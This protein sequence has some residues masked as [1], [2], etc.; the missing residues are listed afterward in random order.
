MILSSQQD[1]AT[2][3]NIDSLIDSLEHL[4]PEDATISEKDLPKYYR[5]G[6]YYDT[7]GVFREET[8]KDRR[9]K[10]LLRMRDFYKILKD[11]VVCILP[12]PGQEFVDGIPMFQIFQ[13]D[14]TG[15]RAKQAKPAKKK[16][17]DEIF[18]KLGLQSKYTNNSV[19]KLVEDLCKLEIHKFQKRMRNVERS[20]SLQQE[21]SKY[22]VVFGGSVEQGREKRNARGKEGA[23]Q[24][25]GAGGA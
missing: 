16:K 14:I 1:E 24:K 21:V 2:E 12:D 9:K 8:D 11:N 25:D 17:I 22:R 7:N 3:A 15:R 23:K 5:N 4:L 6:D 13:H 19:S 10:Q 20:R 18:E